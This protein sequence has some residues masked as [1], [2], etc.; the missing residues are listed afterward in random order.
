MQFSPAL[1]EHAKYF[2]KFKMKSE[3]GLDDVLYTSSI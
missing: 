2:V 3:R 1:S